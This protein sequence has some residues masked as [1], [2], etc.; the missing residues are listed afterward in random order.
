MAT[1]NDH[2]CISLSENV[3]KIAEVKGGAPSGKVAQ[4]LAQDISGVA[5]DAL[6]S[7]IQKSLKGLNTKGST[8][9]LMVPPGVT[10]SKNIE[11]PSVDEEEIKSI[12]NCIVLFFVI[13]NFFLNKNK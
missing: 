13:F 4:C 8:I 10:T 6:P 5:E 9:V 2:I 11:I 12:V 7:L 1:K 3:L